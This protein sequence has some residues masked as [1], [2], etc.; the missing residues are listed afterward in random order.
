MALLDLSRFGSAR[1]H[2]LLQTTI[3]NRQA[4]MTLMQRE[5]ALTTSPM[6]KEAYSAKP[7]MQ[8]TRRSKQQVK[9]WKKQDK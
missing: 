6:T 7:S 4:M 5:K 3:A 1:P 8:P 2:L 9:R